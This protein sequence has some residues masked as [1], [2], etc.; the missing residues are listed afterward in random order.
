VS[1]I[2][3]CLLAVMLSFLAACAST[4]G[5]C[6]KVREYQLA[7]NAPRIQVPEGLQPLNDS[8]RLEIPEGARNQTATALDQPCLDYPP[9]YFRGGLP[10]ESKKSKKRRDRAA[11]KEDAAAAAAE[12]AAADAAVDD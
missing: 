12:A 5:R 1:F 11:E 6:Y 4:K 3:L 9:R 8:V 2:R 10:T 7:E